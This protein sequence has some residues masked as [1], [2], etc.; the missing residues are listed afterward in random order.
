MKHFTF[1]I[2]IFLL[3]DT[4]SFAQNNT[5][6][7]Q[8]VFVDDNGIM[9]WKNSNEEVKLFGVNYT[10][11]FAYSYRAQ[12]KLGLS[13]KQAI[14]LDVA[15]MVRLG[16]DAFRVHVWDREI[17]DKSG[18]IIDNEHLD[19]LD[20]L[21]WR[22]QSQGIKTIL[23]PIAWWGNGWP[24]PDEM[25]SGFSQSY[26]RLQLITDQNARTAQRNYLKQFVKHRNPYS[27]FTYGNDPS[28]IAMEIIN[29]PSHPENGKEVT[30][31]INEMVGA[32]RETG[33]TKPLFYNISQN[34]NE[35][36]AQAVCYANV[37]GIS[38][39]WYPT[40]L[41]HNKMLQGNFLNNVNH[42]SIPS[43]KISGYNKKAKMV[44]EFEAADIGGSYM[45]PAMAR[46]FRE[47][48]MQFAT[49]FSYEPSQIAWSNTE[50]PT[51][52]LNLLYTPSKAI[53][54]MIAGFAF[55]ELPMKKS[56]GDYPANNKFENF[57]VSYDEDLS[58][59][60]SD[61][62]FFYSN[63]TNDIPRN[64]N[65]LEHI[66][67]CGNSKLVKY[68]GTGAYFL[69]KL[70]NGIWKLEVYPDVLWLADPFEQ[71]SMSRQVARLYWKERGMSITLPDLKNKFFINSVNGKKEISLKVENSEFKIKPGVYLLS[72][73][74]LNKNTAEKYLSGSE[75]FLSGLYTPPGKS[76]QVNVVNQSNAHQLDMEP[77][78]LKFQIASENEITNAEIF[79]K[80]FGWRNF[81]KY[82]LKKMEGFTYTFEDSSKMFS[83]GEFQY[84][85]AVKSGETVRSFPGEILGS[86]E[87]WDFRMN[88]LWTVLR[89]KSG[90]SINLFSPLRD[91]RDL[92]FPH[93][94]HTMQYDLNYKM[95]SDG[96]K[97]SLSVKVRY[98]NEN[99]IPFGLQIPIVEKIKS[100]YREPND[101]KYIVL[102]G[103]SNQDTAST[104]RL[105][106]LTEEGEI[107]TSDIEL[108]NG[109]TNVAIP[110]S[111][112]QNGEALML[113]SAYPLF[114]PKFLQSSNNI[115]NK[116]LNP[117]MI[118]AIQIVCDE[119]GRKNA[120]GELE[121]G[122]EIESVYLTNKR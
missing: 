66:A 60:N 3:M 56:F 121:I 54:L 52:F 98:T 90:E 15:Q 26:S 101:Y 10:T 5:S 27:K 6:K 110:L 28:I 4:F 87:D 64:T 91:R 61:T 30:E 71:T 95:G 1:I 20:Y 97:I 119:T 92:L 7:K 53:S 118:N 47:A 17:S 109:W 70:E 116:G 49:M 42:Y 104:I 43:E 99:K 55:H 80:R 34:W 76:H 44:Y 102:R 33:Y 108:Q 85:V 11:P 22:L 25:T 93:F 18:N 88:D 32:I 69:E 114:L 106:L 31:Y 45:Y 8:D 72:V 81:A 21:V 115:E 120:E 57:R 23:T 2:F 40:D 79:I 29:E 113:P 62:C 58:I 83:E 86:P 46:S 122:F 14:D 78:R 73:S 111:T 24:E 94:S 19:L 75:K 59:A 68:D 100:V 39:Q 51:H 89:S 12:K 13:L 74:K 37:Q 36:Q 35:V 63:N 96:D 117:F 9:R 105:N 67:G 50:Y 84:C 77:L 112:F 107:F 16:F 38:F 65:A 48:G 103:R 41:V 82:P